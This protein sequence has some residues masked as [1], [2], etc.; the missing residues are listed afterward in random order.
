MRS[1]FHMALSQAGLLRQTRA[2]DAHDEA[3]LRSELFTADQMEQHGKSVA[4]AH[5]LTLKHIVDRLLPRLADNEKTLVEACTLLARSAEA[6]RR[7]TPAGEWLL[8]NFYLIEEE[9]RTAKRHLPKGYSRE[10]P[11]LAQG[12]SAKLPRVYDLAFEAISHGD[13]RVDAESLSRFVAAYQTVAP[14]KGG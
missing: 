14:L 11:R 7:V 9:I 12:P 6:H 13:G 8:D 3:P 2:R 5:E 4:A 10:L 1:W